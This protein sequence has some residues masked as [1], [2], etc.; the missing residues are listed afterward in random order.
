MH[1]TGYFYPAIESTEPSISLSIFSCIFLLK[2]RW[3]SFALET[4]I[5]IKI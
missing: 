1:G 4:P 3:K 5:L 2:F